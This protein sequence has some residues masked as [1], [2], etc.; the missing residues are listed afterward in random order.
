MRMKY[1]KQRR[2]TY[3]YQRRIPEALQSVLGFGMYSR[4]LKTHDLATA[5]KLAEQINQKWQ[6]LQDESRPSAAYAK[7][8]E[9]VT[10]YPHELSDA[11]AQSDPDDQSGVFSAFPYTD[12]LTYHAAQERLS[13]KPRRPEYAYSLLDGRDALKASKQGEVETKTLAKYDRAV[14]VF[15]GAKADEPLGAITYADVAQWLDQIKTTASYGTRS[16]YL[17]YLGQIYEHAQRREHVSAGVNPFRRQQ[18]G[19]NEV[20]SYRLMDDD[21]LRAILELLDTRDHLPALVARYSGM[22]LSEIFN[23]ELAEVDGVWCFQ[24]RPSDSYRG[25]KTEAGNRTVPIRKCLIDDV[26]ASHGDWVNHAAYSK[27]FGRAK[28]KVLGHADRTMAFHSLRVAFITYAGRARY[29]EQQVAWLV[30][31]EE[32][33]GSAMT[34]QLYFK[35]YTLDLMQEIV[36]AVPEFEKTPT[37]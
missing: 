30:G 1:L 4:S 34:G 17:S 18:H 22:R 11:L 8:L 7:V 3:W 28:T 27:K 15:L 19:K 33:K 36:E 37:Q 2:K 9:S 35:G 6:T 16:D 24:V 32:G 14:S 25:A 5:V 26:R 10:E 29:S 31:H 13:G 21:T 12:R 20:Q 23:S